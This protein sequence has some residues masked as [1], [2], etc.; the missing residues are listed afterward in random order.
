M[1][2]KGPPSPLL[3]SPAARLLLLPAPQ[4]KSTYQHPGFKARHSPPSGVSRHTLPRQP[5]V[6][7]SLE[8]GHHMLTGFNRSNL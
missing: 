6:S 4:E 1:V 7:P 3:P 5:Q 8:R 2:A